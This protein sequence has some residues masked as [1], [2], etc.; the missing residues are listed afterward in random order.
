[1]GYWHSGGE[2]V[3]AGGGEWCLLEKLPAL[4]PFTVL[5]SAV[6]TPTA[7]PFCNTDSEPSCLLAPLSLNL[8]TPDTEPLGE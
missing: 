7:E 4:T 8:N 5:S 1:M 2:G 6:G 3:I